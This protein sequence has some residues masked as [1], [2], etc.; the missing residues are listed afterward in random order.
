M[1]PIFVVDANRC[2][3]EELCR[4]LEERGESVVPCDSAGA[5]VARVLA[6]PVLERAR[7]SSR[8]LRELK[9][10]IP[11]GEQL[12]E[13]QVDL[14]PLQGTSDRIERRSGNVLPEGAYVNIASTLVI[15]DKTWQGIPADLQQAVRKAA[16]ENGDFAFDY[17]KKNEDTIYANSTKNAKELIR[18]KDIEKWQAATAPVI[19][20]FGEKFGK[21]YADFIDWVKSTR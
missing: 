9:L 17:F 14:V 5:A 11:D 8:V 1:E 13:G 20:Q 16:D 3:R 21:Q 12:P 15:S 19:D 4:R 18:V 6:S 7:G 2:R 10:G